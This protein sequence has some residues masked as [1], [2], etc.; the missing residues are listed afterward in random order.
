MPRPDPVPA[1]P[2][3]DKSRL[4]YAIRLVAAFAIVVAVVACLLVAAGDEEFRPHMLIATA[5]GSFLTVMLGGALIL[6]SYFSSASG[7]DQ[8]VADFNKDDKK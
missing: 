7:H 4:R 2:A 3:A 8:E 5:A 6:V 1:A